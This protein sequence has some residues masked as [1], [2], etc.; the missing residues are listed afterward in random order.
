V[1][2][3]L[4]EIKEDGTYTRIYRKWFEQDPPPETFGSGGSPE[5]G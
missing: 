4:R 2:P 3:V 5:G 1:N